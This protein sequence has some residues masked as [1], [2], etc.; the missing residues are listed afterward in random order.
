MPLVG[1]V[2]GSPSDEPYAKETTDIL[3][4]LGISHEVNF[5]SAHRTPEKA[6]EY[7]ITAR[8]RGLGGVDCRSRDGGAPAGRYGKLD[9]A[10]GNRRAS[11]RERP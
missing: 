5:L 6:R 7:G 2:M 11:A 1:I 3:D 4:K 10:S 9:D 8:E